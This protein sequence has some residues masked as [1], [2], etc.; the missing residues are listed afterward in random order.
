MNYRFIV[1]LS[2]CG[3]HYARDTETLLCT[4]FTYLSLAMS[5][6][7]YLYCI[8]CCLM[9]TT[10]IFPFYSYEPVYSDGFKVLVMSFQ[11]E[12]TPSPPTLFMQ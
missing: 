9:P 5:T 10:M 1:L 12:S 4:P 2:I 7:R 11:V 3:L 6:F 8:I